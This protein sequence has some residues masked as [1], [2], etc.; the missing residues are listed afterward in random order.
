MV[1]AVHEKSPRFLNQAL[2]GRMHRWDDGRRMRALRYVPLSIAMLLVAAPVAL[3]SV[4][5]DSGPPAFTNSSPAHFTF[6]TN[7]SA[8][9]QCKVDNATYAACTSPYDVNGVSE[10]SHTF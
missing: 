6:S 8:P 1:R 3:A 7:P 10:G 2:P 5:I 9:T 4:T